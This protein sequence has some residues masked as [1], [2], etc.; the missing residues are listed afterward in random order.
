[1]QIHRRQN[2]GGSL[3]LTA[4]IST[5]LY[6]PNE[7]VHHGFTMP[8]PPSPAHARACKQPPRLLA[9]PA[10]RPRATSP[11]PR[12]EPARGSRPRCT[13]PP[14]MEPAHRPR[15]AIPAPSPRSNRHRSH[16][17]TR[18]SREGGAY[19]VPLSMTTAGRDKAS[20]A[21]A[22][23]VVVATRLLSGGGSRGGAC[24]SG[25]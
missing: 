12:M 7:D 21:C 24:S 9:P 20:M 22:K 1:V 5:I 6:E 10:P 4:L 11:C 25:G 23:R 3:P 13:P 2:Q 15:R 17:S 8:P 16:A 18:R 14:R 19:L